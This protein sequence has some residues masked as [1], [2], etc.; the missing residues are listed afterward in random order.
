VVGA[1]DY[2]ALISVALERLE[3]ENILIPCASVEVDDWAGNRI[4]GARHLQPSRFLVS[5]TK[6]AEIPVGVLV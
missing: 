4:G 3:S 5:G 6:V 2:R 1:P